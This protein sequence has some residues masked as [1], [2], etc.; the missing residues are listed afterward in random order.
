MRRAATI[1]A[2]VAAL[3]L[4]GGLSALAGDLRGDADGATGHADERLYLPDGDFLRIASLG[5]HAPAADYAWLQAVQYYGGYRL[6]NHDLR[7]FD[8]LVDAVT[9]LDPHFEDAYVLSSLIHCVDFADHAGAVDVLK[10][11]LLHNPDS[12]RL[13]FEIGFIHY[14]FTG[15][16][17][18]A[19]RWFEAAAAKPGAS[20]FCRRFAAWSAGRGGDL[21]GALYLWE[22][23][24]QTTDNQD[25]RELAAGMV[26]K[27]EAALAGEPLPGQIGPPSPS[28]TGV[29]R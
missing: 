8:G 22:N 15:E 19:A 5:Y 23:L 17:A 18:V 13:C 14:V 12:W 1:L 4:V 7:Y 16:F 26:E 6:G 11:G 10:R 21:L 9:T 28:S 20:D 24:R 3:A 25:M 27:L 2:A 29:N